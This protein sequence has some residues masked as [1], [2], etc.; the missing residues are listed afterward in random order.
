MLGLAL[1]QLEA[2]EE[3]DDA[4]GAGGQVPPRGRDRLGGMRMQASTR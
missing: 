3:I 1:A 4:G 2:L